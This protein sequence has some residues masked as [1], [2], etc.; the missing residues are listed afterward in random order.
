[1]PLKGSY[2]TLMSGLQKVRRS[3]LSKLLSNKR[4]YPVITATA[5]VLFRI[6][7]LK[8][9]GLPANSY[10]FVVGVPLS[11]APW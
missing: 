8:I 4:K 5:Q 10:N 1:V 6:A 9:A 3:E 2:E 11:D 7:D